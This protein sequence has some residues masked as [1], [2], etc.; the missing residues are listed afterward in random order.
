MT[1]RA[2]NLAD[3]LDEALAWTGL[4]SGLV[5]FGGYPQALAVTAAVIAVQ[6][7]WGLFR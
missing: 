7:V 6:G 1:R 5:A 4:I 3:A 2:S